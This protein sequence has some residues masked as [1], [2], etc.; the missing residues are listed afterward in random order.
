MVAMFPFYV[1]KGAKVFQLFHGRDSGTSQA[2]RPVATCFAG[3]RQASC[4]QTLSAE[5]IGR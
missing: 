5:S 3:F 2:F 1:G 4:K